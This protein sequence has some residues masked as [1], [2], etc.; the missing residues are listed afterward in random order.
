[1]VN[2]YNVIVHGAA[3][4]PEKRVVVQVKVVAVRRYEDLIKE[5]GN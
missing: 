3:K 4:A 2:K 5:E 1:M